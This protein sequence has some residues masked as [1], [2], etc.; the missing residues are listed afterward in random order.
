MIEPAHHFPPRTSYAICIDRNQPLVEQSFRD[1]AAVMIS[2]TL[3]RSPRDCLLSVPACKG[4]A[5]ARNR[6]QKALHAIRP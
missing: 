6:A 5:A 1:V 2:R 3:G 4:D